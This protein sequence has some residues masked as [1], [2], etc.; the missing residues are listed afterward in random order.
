MHPDSS[1]LVK[2]LSDYQGPALLA[3]NDTIFLGERFPITNVLG[4][5]HSIKEASTHDV[6]YAMD[7]FANDMG[8][9]GLLS[10][11]SVQRIVLSIDDQ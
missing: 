4:R 11:K 10:L 8:S 9:N 6:R 5:L 2:G 7:S 1:V 3:Y